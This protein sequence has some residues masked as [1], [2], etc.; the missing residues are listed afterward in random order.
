MRMRKGAEIAS[1]LSK[2]LASGFLFVVILVEAE[3]IVAPSFNL[4][5]GLRLFNI[6]TISMSNTW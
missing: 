4:F 6:F 3:M 1:I 5:N 2:A